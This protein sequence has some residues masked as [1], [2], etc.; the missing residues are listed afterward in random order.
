RFDLDRL[1]LDTGEVWAVV[2]VKIQKRREDF[3]KPPMTWDERFRGANGQTYRGAWVLL[4]QHWRNKGEP[5][6]IPNGMLAID[7]VPPRT[8][9][10]ALRDLVRRD[11]IRV[12]WRKKKSPIVRVVV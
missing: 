7:G 8:K 3:V 10:R 6:K 5:F 9:C 1:R 4:Y 2:P 11:L 12:E